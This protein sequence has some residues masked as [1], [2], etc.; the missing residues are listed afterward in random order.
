MS[1]KTFVDGMNV[2]EFVF[3]DGGKVYN[4]TFFLKDFWDFCEKHGR[5]YQDDKGIERDV[6]TITLKKSRNKGTWYPELNTREGQPQSQGGG[7]S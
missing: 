4:L 5:K 3:D 2:K 1:D 7:F 6:I